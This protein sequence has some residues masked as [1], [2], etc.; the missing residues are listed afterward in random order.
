MISFVNEPE[1]TLV[2]DGEVFHGINIIERL[3]ELKEQD[4]EA[5][6]LFST[7]ARAYASNDTV[8]SIGFRL[9]HPEAVMPTKRI[10]DI[11]FDLTVIDVSKTLTQLTTMYETY[12]SLDIPIGYYVELIPRSSLS[13]T[14][15]LLANSVGVIDPCFTGTLKV[16][17]VK[18]DPSMPDLVLP[19]KVAQLVL[20]PYVICESYDASNKHKVETIRGDGGFGS[21][22]N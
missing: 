16:P 5:S 2:V 21:T 19:A 7:L 12:V 10:V 22:S 6:R 11:G 14:G 3:H 1:P 17:L 15:Y 13:K 8:P 9:Q 18:V 20:K 4:M